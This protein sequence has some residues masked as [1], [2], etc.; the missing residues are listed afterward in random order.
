[1]LARNKTTSVLDKVAETLG[2]DCV[3]GWEPDLKPGKI[4][5]YEDYQ[6]VR[7]SDDKVVV[8]YLCDDDHASPFFEDGDCNGE[9][10]QFRSE[11]A[12]DEWIERKR[13]DGLTVFIVDKYE[14]GQVHYSLANTEDYPDRRW[15][16]APCAALACDFKAWGTPP[17]RQ[18][19]VAKGI[20][21]EYTK[22]C[23]GE[24]YGCVTVELTIDRETGEVVAETS[25]SV[26]GC[27]GIEWARDCLTE[28]MPS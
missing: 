3:W 16:V 15:D 19:D 2:L 14:H 18:R 7:V 24:V 11:D 12:R 22:W 20:L 8:G 21:E 13:D 10:K 23:N 4:M 27:I 5:H 9:F 26:W 17:E 6:I 28:E 25:N 1:M